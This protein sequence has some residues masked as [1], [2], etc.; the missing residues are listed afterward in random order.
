MRDRGGP[1]AGRGARCLSLS[2][3]SRLLAGY[4]GLGARGTHRA[5][6]LCR[7]TAGRRDGEP[8][9]GEIRAQPP[10]SPSWGR[11]RRLRPGRAP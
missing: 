10:Q 7:R 4:S 8:D 5:P 1:D 9:A 11:G 3:F 2:L 6:A